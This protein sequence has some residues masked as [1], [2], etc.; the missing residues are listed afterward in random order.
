LPDLL[1]NVYNDQDQF[2]T[3][4]KHERQIEFFAEQKRYYDL[5]RWKDADV[6]E[7]IPI[8]GCN[9]DM[10]KSDTQKQNFYTPTVVTSYP[11]IFLDAMYLWPIPHYELIRNK[12][13][14]QNPGW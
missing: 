10:T 9:V 11:K 6:E 3:A 7:N 12:R 13:L 14:T 2:R 8:K 1:D 4:L 5:R